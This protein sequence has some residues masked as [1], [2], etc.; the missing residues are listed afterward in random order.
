MGSFPADSSEAMEIK[1]PLIF[2]DPQMNIAVNTT[3]SWSW[4]W[5]PS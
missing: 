2:I 1:Q 4:L 3:L 5:L